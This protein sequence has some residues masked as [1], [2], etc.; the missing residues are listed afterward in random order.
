MTCSSSRQEA[1]TEGEPATLLQNSVPPT[2]TTFSIRKLQFGFNTSDYYSIVFSILSFPLPHSF[3]VHKVT[4]VC[5]QAFA[6]FFLTKWPMVCFDLH[7][8]EMGWG[9]YWFCENTPFSISGM[10]IQLLSL[11]SSKLFCS[12][13]LKKKKKKEQHKNSCIPCLIGEF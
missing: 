8:M 9:K 13:C 2:K 11:Y 3:I 10:L 6:F 7:Q 5:A 12:H 4:G 1:S